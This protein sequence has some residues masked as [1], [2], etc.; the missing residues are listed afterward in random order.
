MNFK[1][2]KQA[3]LNLGIKE[4][5]VL[6]INVEIRM[7]EIIVDLQKAIPAKLKGEYN[8][9]RGA[10]DIVKKGSCYFTITENVGLDIDNYQ[11]EEYCN[12]AH[13][14]LR[15]L[16]KAWSELGVNLEVIYYL[17]ADNGLIIANFK[18]W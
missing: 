15:R 5:G 6:Y 4:I 7:K 8:L 9:K 1:G 2:I 3:V 13:E 18:A 11:K 12:L 10:V 14:K 17:P 16:I